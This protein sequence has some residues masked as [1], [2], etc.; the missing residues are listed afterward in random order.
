MPDYSIRVFQINYYV[1]LHIPALYY[2]FKNNDLNFDLIYQKWIMTIYSNYLPLDKLLIVWHFFLIDKWEAIIKYALIILSLCKDKLMKVD[3]EKLC[4]FIKTKDWLDE[5]NN[6][7]FFNMYLEIDSMFKFT[8]LITNE[9]LND[10]KEQ[11]YMNLVENKLD[12]NDSNHS[13]GKVYNKWADDQI[14]AIEKYYFQYNKINKVVKEQIDMFKKK[15]ETLTKKYQNVLKDYNYNLSILNSLKTK[16]T[17]LVDENIALKMVVDNL[18]KKK[19]YSKSKL[20]ELVNGSD[21][22]I[23]KKKKNSFLSNFNPLN[24]LRKSSEKNEEHLLFDIEALKLKIK[25]EVIIE[26]INKEN[27]KCSEQVILNFSFF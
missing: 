2:Y 1:K 6:Q 23:L 3:L 24:Y 20:N 26:E 25:S 19:D 4:H 11:F 8:N 12:K 13:I 15:I 17:N 9:S 18:N 10:L 14:Q 21:Y 27:K 16:L 5:I 22:G 7:D